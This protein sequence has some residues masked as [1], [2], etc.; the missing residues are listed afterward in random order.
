MLNPPPLR[1]AINPAWKGRT[2]ESILRHELRFSRKQII[3]LK[4]RNGVFLDGRSVLVK[5]RLESTGGEL[6][7]LIP[8]TPQDILPE[9]IPLTILYEDPDLIVI[10]KPAGLLVHP[11]RF[12][13]TGTLA[14]ALTYHWQQT[15][16]TASFHPVHRLDKQ[17]SGLLLIAKSSWSHQQLFLQLRAHEIHRTYLAFTDGNP[18]RNSGLLSAPIKRAGTGM[19]RIVAADGQTALTRYRV[20][21]RSPTSA[22][23]LLQIITGRTHQIRVH[24]SHL[25]TALIGDPLYGQPSAWLDRPALHAAALRFRHPRSRQLLKFR[26][27]LPPDL[28]TLGELLNLL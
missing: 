25:G 21:R 19:R 2:I 18:P 4:K 17:T 12:H 16:E 8:P 13:L 11:V 27:P 23:L 28:E 24:L 7:I 14:N 3:T 9:K 6:L 1:I 22:L 10:D 20:L 5:E 15:G 26:A